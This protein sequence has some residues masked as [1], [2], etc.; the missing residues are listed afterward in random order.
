MKEAEP[1]KMIEAY[2]RRTGLKA[3]QVADL[4]KIPRVTIY[5]FLSGNKD[6]RLAQWRS[7][8]RLIDRA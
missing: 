3:Y 6:L 7:V 1:R 5:R 8:E 4:A 2:M